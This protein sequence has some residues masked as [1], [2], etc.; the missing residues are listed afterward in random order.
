M[1][2][3][4]FEDAPVGI[5]VLSADG[6]VLA[7]NPQL[8]AMLARTADELTGRP[9]G[10]LIET[11]V[12]PDGCAG[13]LADLRAA[14]LGPPPTGPAGPTPSGSNE[15]RREVCLHT[16][17][18]GM[19]WVLLRWAADDPPGRVVV[20][21]CE[22]A[23][24][25]DPAEATRELDEM[26]QSLVTVSG[27]GIA[28]GDLDERIRRVNPELCDMLG[29]TAD[30]L[31]AMTF[32]DITHPDDWEKSRAYVQEMSTQGTR[33]QQTIKRYLRKDGR[34]LYCRRAIYAGR[35]RDGV[36]RSVLVVVEPLGTA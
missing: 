33:R 20:H 5:A 23:A 17:H 31:M 22:L 14:A 18:D 1:H 30:E 7:A 13:L 8:C 16:S 29:Y 4:A 27:F 19:A 36:M 35:G 24:D 9:F 28:V 32:R 6:T 12:H 25:R 3:A 26:V 34:A 11:R 21:A 10:E 2:R 15:R